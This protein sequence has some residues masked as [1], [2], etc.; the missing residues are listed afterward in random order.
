MLIKI[1][2][3]YI[4][5]GCIAWI[6]NKVQFSELICK[7]TLAEWACNCR[8]PECS[9]QSVRNCCPI[10]LSKTKKRPP[11]GR[12]K[13]KGRAREQ[14]ILTW[15]VGWV[16]LLL[17]EAAAVALDAAAHAEEAADAGHAHHQDDP[18]GEHDEHRHAQ[19]QD[20][21]HLVTG[22]RHTHN[23]R[24]SLAA[25]ANLWP[26]RA[27]PAAAK[28]AGERP[29]PKMDDPMNVKIIRAPACSGAFTCAAG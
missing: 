18:D 10:N 29:R 12:K 22:C 25:S 23:T 8:G 21:A 15:V 27:P 20:G 26:R 28:N 6:V 13:E 14:R 3:L 11:R 2:K 1:I 7:G 5:H 19:A 9:S 16:G 17:W 24:A 4:K